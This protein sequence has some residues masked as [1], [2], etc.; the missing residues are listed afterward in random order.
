MAKISTQ[1][2]V[3]IPNSEFLFLSFPVSSQSHP[4]FNP[5]L[6]HI[7]ELHT[8]LY[9]H[10][11]FLEPTSIVSIRFVFPPAGMVTAFQASVTAII[12]Y[13]VSRCF[14]DQM[15]RI[16]TIACGHR[17]DS[18]HNHILK[19]FSSEGIFSTCSLV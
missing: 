6:S 14:N 16:W 19:K 3:P 13:S 1:Q 12:S 5:K 11:L 9:T 15:W 7:F 2:Q 4:S 17:Q 18:R 10:F 8:S